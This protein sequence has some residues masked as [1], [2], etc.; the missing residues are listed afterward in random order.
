MF[1]RLVEAFKVSLRNDKQIIRRYIILGAFDGILVSI[2]VLIT[3]VLAG[4]SLDKITSVVLAGIMG[5]TISSM[6]NTLVVEVKE[7]REELKHLEMQMMRTL[8]GTIYDYSFKISIILSTLSHSFSPFI[9][10]V[11]LLI[12][13][14]TKNVL[15]TIVFSSLA[16][17]GLGVV[18]EGDL[19]EKLG[20]AVL[21]FI[22]GIIA[23]LLSIL[24]S[25]SP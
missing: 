25:T 4:E 17:S 9:G 15:L 13:N 3:S 19:K 11:T 6:W 14:L 8:K 21:M 20:T 12:Y 10:L 24:I 23:S 16:L 2:S 22:A 5:V 18:Y 1:E 7:K